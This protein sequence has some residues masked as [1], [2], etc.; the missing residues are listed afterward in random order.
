MTDREN[1]L[2]L[3]DKFTLS[4]EFA[5]KIYN[6]VYRNMS[7]TLTVEEERRIVNKI[8]EILFQ[9]N[10]DYFFE[11]NT[12][13]TIKNVYKNGSKVNNK[14]YRDIFEKDKKRMIKLLESPLYEQKLTIKPKNFTQEQYNYLSSTG[15]NKDVL[16]KMLI[17][18]TLAILGI[19][20]ETVEDPRKRVFKYKELINYQETYLLT[21]QLDQEREIQIK[22]IKALSELNDF[23]SECAHND[24]IDKVMHSLITNQKNIRLYLPLRK[25][26]ILENLP[27]YSNISLERCLFQNLDLFIFELKNNYDN[28]ALKKHL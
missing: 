11:L 20:E 15:F 4:T 13:G 12:D 7:N 1:I 28:K 24:I 14:D 3:V 23:K 18:E 2:K 5:E 27:E 22:I 10:L 17:K 26:K 9:N 25:E 8:H 19:K 21:S 16:N 6:E